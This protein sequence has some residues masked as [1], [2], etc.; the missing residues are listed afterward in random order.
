MEVEFTFVTQTTHG[1]KPVV[2]AEFSPSGKLIASS[3]R[4]DVAAFFLAHLIIM[5]FVS[6]GSDRR[7]VLHNIQDGSLHDSF[8]E[9]DHL[10]GINQVGWLTD[11]LIVTAAD[12][13]LVR[14]KS[15][16]E[17]RARCLV[18]RSDHGQCDK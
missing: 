17:V 7:V 2:S 6:T 16:S 5:L 10:A 18:R 13:G 11:D 1:G 8:P 15:L 12:D 9:E 14:I 3:G 4:Q